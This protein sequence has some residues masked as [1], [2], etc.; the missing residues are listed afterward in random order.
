MIELEN[1]K[2]YITKKLDILIS[3][4]ISTFLYNSRDK[5]KQLSSQMHLDKIVE[6]LNDDKIINYNFLFLSDAFEIMSYY[7]N[8]IFFSAKAGIDKNLYKNSDEQFNSCLLTHDKK[9]I[10]PIITDF[11]NAKLF[12]KFNNLREKLK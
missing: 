4:D 1:N 10:Y 3:D 7:K 9:S 5:S 6:K 11:N 2:L 12:E 8:K